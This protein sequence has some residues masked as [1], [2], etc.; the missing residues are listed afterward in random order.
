MKK[1]K[2]LLSFTLIFMFFTAFAEGW[3]KNEMQVK[4]TLNNPV[5]A[6]TLYNLKLNGDFFLDYAIIYVVPSELEK[7]EHAGLEYE[8]QIE[9]LN[10]FYKDFWD[11]KDAYHSY[12]EIID[13][14]DSLAENFPDI[15]EKYIFGTSVG[16]RQLVAL[17]ISDNVGVDEPEPEIMFDGGIHGD[18]I[19]CSENVIRF[20]RD[21]C[22]KYDVDPVV[23][24][25]INNREIWLYLMVNPDG[26][27]NVSRYNNN[28]VD[29][30]RDWGY[31]WDGWG[32]STGAYSQPE[33]K[34][35]REC[36]LNNQF[37]V[38]TTYHS[39]TE[40]ISCPWSYRASTP[41]D[42]GNILQLAG[43]YSDV[44][45]YPDLEYGQGC[46][47]MYPIN[48]S[49]K[50]SNYGV[51]GSISWSMEISYSKQ[52][53]ASQIMMYYL[54]NYPSMLTM[55]EYSGYGVEGTVTD[56]DTGDPIAAVVFV[57]N[58]L[59]RYTD[60][61]QGDYHKYVLPGTY[62]ITVKANGYQTK[63]VGN[64]VVTELSSTVTDIELDPEEHQS[65][66]KI[67]SSQIP[68]NN[69]ADEGTTWF[70]I[71]QPDNMNYSIGKN[72]W[73]VVDMQ[74]LI[75]DGPG[76]DIIVFEGDDTPE[77]YTIYAGETMDGPWKTMGTGNGTTE[78]D[79]ENCTLS[80]ARYF[81]ILDD[82]DGSAGVN[83]AGFDLDAVQSLSSITGPY[84]VLEGYV[85]D[86]SNGN[87]NGQLD[88]GETADF[89]I[90]LKNIGS[91]NALDIIGTLSTNDQYI[92]VI[93]TEPQDFGDILINETASATFTVSADES[94]PAGHTSTLEL[95]YEGS[96]ITASVKY[97]QV[98]FPDYCY[99]TA[100]CS[101]GDG[102]T[103]FA[104][105]DISNLNS[106]CSPN[107]YGDFTDME[108]ELESGT[109]YTVSWES[110]YSNQEAC[111]WIDLN[112]DM[113][114]DEDERLITD[115][116]IANS[117]QIYN[118]D[119]TV[120]DGVSPG[121]KRLRIRANWQN[122]AADPC[123]DFS[124][125]E[126][127]DYTVVFQ[128]GINAGF[129]SDATEVCYGWEVH[130]Y[131]ISTGNI[132]SWE[133]T[134]YGG[135][136]STSNIQNPVV[137]YNTPGMYGVSLTVSDGT[138]S[139]TATIP[140]YIIVFDDPEIPDV[141]TGETEMCQDSP[142][143]TYY[144]NPGSA[145]D[146]VWELNPQEAGAISWVGPD[147]EV[148]WDA[149]FS[150]T[151]YIKVAA[152]N[153]CG[154]SNFSDEL[155]VTI[156]PFPAPA[157]NISGDDVVCQE[158]VVIY[159]VPE[160]GDATEY[161]WVL[162]PE[163]AGMML[164]NNNICTITWSDS[165]EGTAELKVRGINE[166]GEGE[167]S[168]IFE[169]LVQ[170]CTGITNNT[171]SNSIEVKPN[172]NNGTFTVEFNSSVS[173]KVNLTILN[174]LGVEVYSNFGLEMSS[175]TLNLN[176]NHL[177]NGIYYLM[178]DNGSIKLSKKIIIQQ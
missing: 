30:N 88:P 58:F 166:C 157:E 93:T 27:V 66:Y 176:L 96:N 172:P 113:V 173:G 55:I 136:P 61:D 64:I 31:M 16:G 111:L 165:W 34:A 74:E 52:P 82:G 79:F 83:D 131:D 95:A 139:S 43:V 44:S 125:G 62:S 28:G 23:T 163:E 97:L 54:R 33:S 24:E 67:I 145:T 178:I 36:M 81:K 68:N 7:I 148:D 110:G 150:G 42:A 90:T 160:I 177:K 120:P 138:N 147:A 116:N 101:Y 59:P 130:Y 26:R 167:W 45:G 109:T 106:G 22:L 100:N 5:Q 115:F 92:T 76:A 151:A 174:L 161:E 133:W 158:E 78:F 60:T 40:Y 72:G 175:T 89:I 49:S 152:Q 50:D 57:S 8:I 143:S 107:G 38:H 37:V 128:G 39:G 129:T 105:E 75:M 71:G 86:D 122:S 134:F 164:V 3:R 14:G 156:I 25:L 47:G 121:S 112:D 154:Q 32:N 124:Y 41:P 149:D 48:G 117:G 104:L 1:L 135:T 170:N 123:A 80:E 153:L 155:E 159:T 69:T 46:T 99:P 132:T 102:F 63:V 10:D 29:L 118:T 53:P 4:V 35:L 9:N 119:F 70:V 142:N 94:V 73:V 168:E 56:I 127:E 11:A 15:C 85:V 17:K 171:N 103:S 18:E 137:T 114:F 108:T 91:E 141:P 169:V 6:E 51:M 19:G 87:N 84:I 12:Q 140:E 162:D 21:L 98:L 144:T 77:G 2:L 126:T 13:L 65:V 146:W 20:A